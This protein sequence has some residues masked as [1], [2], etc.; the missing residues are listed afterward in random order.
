VKA[1]IQVVG[2]VCL[3]MFSFA[4]PQEIW[5]TCVIVIDG[6]TIVLDGNEIVRLIGIDTPK[7]LGDLVPQT[8]PTDVA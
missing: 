2:I 5:R 3:L 6:D 8:P 7:L 4:Q 1:R